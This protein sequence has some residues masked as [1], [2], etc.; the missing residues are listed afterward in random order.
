MGLAG[1]GW[2]GCIGLADGE[3]SPA[4]EI[5]GQIRLKSRQ[6]AAGRPQSS[7]RTD[8]VPIV[9]W[10]DW[11]YGPM[12]RQRFGKQDYRP[13]PRA[14]DAKPDS[15]GGGAGLGGSCLLGR[16]IITRIIFRSGEFVRTRQRAG[17]DV[18]DVLYGDQCASK[19]G[20]FEDCW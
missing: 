6:C 15:W 1:Q 2:G 11:L 12:S 16:R 20:A 19:R 4:R 10:S 7:Y 13:W 5:P 9:W 14:R 3:P 8:W 17:R 18:H